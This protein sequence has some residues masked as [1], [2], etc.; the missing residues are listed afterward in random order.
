MN[1]LMHWYAKASNYLC[2]LNEIGRLGKRH[3]LKYLE[4]EV[5]CIIIR[6]MPIFECGNKERSHWCPG[7]VGISACGKTLTPNNLSLS[8]LVRC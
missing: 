1:D 3:R 5:T 4:T 6:I 2:V 7:T 8:L